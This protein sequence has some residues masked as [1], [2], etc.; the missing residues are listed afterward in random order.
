[1]CTTV[2]FH[3]ICHPIPF[4][5]L[6]ELGMHDNIYYLLRGWTIYNCIHDLHNILI[7]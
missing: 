5:G 6:D 1:M 3:L 4:A 2:D 7:S